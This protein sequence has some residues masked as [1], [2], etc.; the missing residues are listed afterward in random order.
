MS[1]A[2]LA[3]ALAA[4]EGES[5]WRID[6]AEKWKGAAVQMEGLAVDGDLLAPI[7][8]QGGQRGCSAGRGPIGEAERFGYS[9]EKRTK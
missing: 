3:S 9:E 6:S 5:S 1:T 7:D 4:A 2:A 8:K